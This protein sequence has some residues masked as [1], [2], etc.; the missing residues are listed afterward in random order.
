MW[1]LSHDRKCVNKPISQLRPLGHHHIDHLVDFQCLPT[2]TAVQNNS[3][4]PASGAK[5]TSL[6]LEL[7]LLTTYVRS[8]YESLS[9]EP[10]YQIFCF[11]YAQF[12]IEL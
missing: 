2:L 7:E 10:R 11:T 12:N 4:P 1:T 3:V 5:T 9:L 6:I 8:S